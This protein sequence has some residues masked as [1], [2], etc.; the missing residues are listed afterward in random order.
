MGTQYEVYKLEY[1]GKIGGYR[2]VDDNNAFAD[3]PV[4]SAPESVKSVILYSGV[5][6]L[7][8]YEE[9]GVKVLRTP[10]EKYGVDNGYIVPS[11]VKS[12]V[13]WYKWD[14]PQFRSAVKNVTSVFS[15]TRV[16]SRI[17]GD[18][19]IDFRSGD[20]DEKFATYDFSF[21]LEQDFGEYSGMHKGEHFE[22]LISRWL[23]G[24]KISYTDI[25]CSYADKGWFSCTIY[26]DG[27][28]H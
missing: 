5:L 13:Q 21:R 19:V 2:L 27:M 14:R 16:L 15:N 22:A 9:N 12:G 3:V 20:V 7:K 6:R 28:G 18:R 24:N 8:M 4:S 23:K 11:G 17:L 26:F 10:Q 25:G 1:G